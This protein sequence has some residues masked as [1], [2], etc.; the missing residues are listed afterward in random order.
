M[1]RVTLPIASL[2]LILSISC[3]EDKAS[4]S[5]SLEKKPEHEQM[6]KT[7]LAS[8]SNETS[9]KVFQNY[10][11]LR[12]ALVNSDLGEAKNA[13]QK[14][15]QGLEEG[16]EDLKSLSLAMMQADDMEKQR[17]LFSDLTEKVT[18]LL[19]ET[20]EGGEIYKQ[21]C[22]M[23]FEGKGGYW[24]SDVAEIRNPYFGDKML[25]CGKVME[26]IN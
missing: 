18:P 11:L 4:K 7:D 5:T 10:Q 14:L 9:E 12:V 20:I 26:T 3:K 8:F 17:S 6:T 24:I 15:T 16:Q 23:A 25:T 2:F 22:P 1:K 13:A 21:Y 19:K